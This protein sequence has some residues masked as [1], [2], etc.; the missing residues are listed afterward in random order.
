MKKCFDNGMMHL[1]IPK[2]DKL[3]LLGI[4]NQLS[5]FANAKLINE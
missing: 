1:Y 4:L 3:F 2:S 5:G